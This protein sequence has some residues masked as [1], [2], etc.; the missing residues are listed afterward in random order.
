MLSHNSPDV[1]AAAAFVLGT[2]ASNNNKFQEQL[3]QLFPESVALLLQVCV[4]C[5]PAFCHLLSA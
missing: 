4:S 1:Q 3:M 2:A 5:V